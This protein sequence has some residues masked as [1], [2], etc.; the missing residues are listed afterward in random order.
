MPFQQQ[1]IADRAQSVVEAAANIATGG[2]GAVVG[3]LTGLGTALVTGDP[4]AGAGVT[5]RVQKSISTNFAGGNEFLKEV[6]G[7]LVGDTSPITKDVTKAVLSSFEG[8]KQ[9]VNLRFGPEAATALHILPVAIAEIVPGLSVFKKANNVPSTIADDVIDEVDLNKTKDGFSEVPPEAKE[10]QQIADDLK[11][12]NAD[13]VAQEVRPDQ[14][15]LDSAERLGVDLNP[16]NY[17]NN[18]AFIDLEQSLKSR[19]GSQL[20]TIEEKAIIDTGTAAD[21]LIV[22]L[23][24]RTDKSLLDIE[25]KDSITSNI[26][27]L[28]KESGPL[29]DKIS[30]NIPKE[31]KVKPLVS[32]AYIKRTLAE[33]GGDESALSSVER[34]LLK[35]SENNPTYAALDRLRKD[36]GSAYQG[37]G[38]FKDD[39]QGNLDQVYKVISEDQQAIV[40]TFG[41]GA[42]YSL[43]RKLVATRKGLEKEAVSLLGKDL[44]NSIIPRM[45]QSAT[46]LSKG[47]VSKLARM[48]DSIPA[49]RRQEVAA[50]MLNDIFTQGGRKGGRSISEGFA[51]AYAGLN[52]N[53]SAKAEL[54]KHLPNI[55]ERRFDDIGKVATGIFRSKALENKSKTARDLISSMNDGG[56]FARIYGAS[57]RVVPLEGIGQAVGIP[58]VGAVAGLLSTLGK[59][60]PKTEIADKLI[61]SRE[62]RLAIEAAA[63]GDTKKVDSL[64]KS[65]VF[66]NWQATQPKNVL[67]EIAALG[68]VGYLT[69]DSE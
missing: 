16:S 61:A 31:I 57:K 12:G 3:G 51:G 13:S 65:K 62:F 10:Y 36:V 18:R 20:A 63:R 66:K 34:R 56:M 67:G 33:L 15:I 42:E 23:G 24:G 19:P 38:P 4:A 47:D 21:K 49:V 32:R 69:G 2:A 43:A 52:R 17:S 37:K 22:D 5:Q 64:I 27:A 9:D 11:A 58:G 35:I 8:A 28:E 39:A 26:K 1:P 60:T 44:G 14:D 40:G 6:V 48:M 68:L 45:T 41:L 50:T 53:P 46:A 30:E 25:V 54:F 59:R 29:Y 7:A 55:A